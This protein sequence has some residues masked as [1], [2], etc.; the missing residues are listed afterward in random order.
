MH[1]LTAA[2]MWQLHLAAS[3]DYQGMRALASGAATC[4]APAHPWL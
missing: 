2:A 4:P 3:A 1:V